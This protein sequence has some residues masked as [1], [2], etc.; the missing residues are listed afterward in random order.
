MK[1][2][3]IAS[4]IGGNKEVVILLYCQSKSPLGEERE[5]EIKKRNR[6][7]HGF[8]SALP[9]SSHESGEEKKTPQLEQ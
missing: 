6:A 2:H 1:S 8:T 5:K 4:T 9:L 7:L 3:C